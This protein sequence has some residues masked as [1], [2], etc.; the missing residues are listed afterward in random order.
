MIEAASARGTGAAQVGSPPREPRR[1]TTRWWRRG[2]R[3]GLGT[4]ATAAVEF[5][6]IA[7]PLLSILFGF[8]ATNIMF[9]T[10]AA[11]QDSAQLAARMVSTGQV[12]NFA[13]GAIT[14]SNTTS[15]VTCSASLTSTQAEYYACQGL[16]SWATFTVTASENCSVP[17]VTVSISV[18]AKS[19]ALADVYSIFTGKTLVAQSVLMKE[20]LCP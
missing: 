15:T 14:T 20:G 9:F 13:N 17:S 12:K 11:M 18:N 10:W 2:G 7:A 1:R 19:A 5:A 8:L 6:V 16:P 4:R 3:A